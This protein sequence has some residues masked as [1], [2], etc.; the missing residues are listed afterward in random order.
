[1]E[2]VMR[3]IAP[4]VT[5]KVFTIVSLLEDEEIEL[6]REL[7]GINQGKVSFQSHRNLQIKR[8]AIL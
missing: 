1:M 8:N 4:E 5:D 2:G 6:E 7:S 3:R